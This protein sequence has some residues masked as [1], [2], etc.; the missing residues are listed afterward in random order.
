MGRKTMTE[1]HKLFGAPEHDPTLNH[2]TL[3]TPEMTSRR[4]P[5]PGEEVAGRLSLVG[6]T[7]LRRMV[8]DSDTD[9]FVDCETG[10]QYTRQQV[11]T[12]QPIR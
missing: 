7:V 8:F 3:G 1:G 10:D 4:T 12:W 6:T 9:R 5:P 2:T 11:E